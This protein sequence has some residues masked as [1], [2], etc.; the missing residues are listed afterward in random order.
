MYK[1]QSLI[2]EHQDQ[3]SS[4]DYLEMC[5]F[6]KS[7]YENKKSNK[8]I[9]LLFNDQIFG[10]LYYRLNE[11]KNKYMKI[12]RETT[13]E[14]YKTKRYYHIPIIIDKYNVLK[15]LLSNFDIDKSISKNKKSINENEILLIDT[16]SIT[17]EKLTELYHN[18]VLKRKTQYL[19]S[20][21]SQYLLRYSLIKDK[22]KDLII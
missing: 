14:Y 13:L 22:I 12:H 21:M 15:K 11:T 18:E 10:D 17:K 2:D 6:M 20:L 4:G 5:N 19:E 7:V 8:A 16:K 3:L 9:D 1:V